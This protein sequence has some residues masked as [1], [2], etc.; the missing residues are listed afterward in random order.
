MAPRARLE[1]RP[2]SSKTRECKIRSVRRLCELVALGA[3]VLL[4]P[5]C[6]RWA[7]VSW[8]VRVRE[9]EPQSVCVR[10]SLS[11]CLVSRPSASVRVCVSFP[12]SHSHKHSLGL[13]LT[14]TR[15]HT[16]NTQAHTPIGALSVSLSVCLSLC[17][18]LCVSLSSPATCSIRFVCSNSNVR[19][20]FPMRFLYHA[21]IFAT[22][23]IRPH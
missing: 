12:L 5:Q 4:F 1:E 19:V 9:R 21:S 20:Q 14:Q 7:L 6:S 23:K 22:A 11:L 18:F 17:V 8:C 15:M 16:T 2:R 10:L 3:P 13:T